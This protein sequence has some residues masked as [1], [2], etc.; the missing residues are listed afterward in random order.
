[1]KSVD[2]NVII[3]FSLPEILA[4]SLDEYCKEY[5]LSRSAAV[6]VILCKYDAIRA[7]LCKRL[8]ELEK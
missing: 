1:M 6:R 2:K 8:K 3:S 7:I 4:N 5:S